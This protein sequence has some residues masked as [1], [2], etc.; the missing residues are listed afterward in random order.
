MQSIKYIRHEINP[1]EKCV[2]WTQSGDNNLL[3]G[4]KAGRWKMGRDTRCTLQWLTANSDVRSRA[5]RRSGKSCNAKSSPL[6][7]HRHFGGIASLRWM[8]ADSP[9]FK[10][11]RGSVSF[12]KV[13]QLS[14][15]H[16][17]VL[18][19]SMVELRVYQVEN[20]QES[21]LLSNPWLTLGSVLASYFHIKHKNHC[22]SEN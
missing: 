1:L 8:S 15:F 12:L 21:N 18:M 4:I 9:D 10:N 3:V 6:S 22:G 19:H 2:V 17:G 16:R 13:V 20:I 11:A 5:A 7:H 14:N